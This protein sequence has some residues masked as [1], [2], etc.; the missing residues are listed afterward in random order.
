MALTDKQVKHR[1]LYAAGAAQCR[2]LEQDPKN[3]RKFNCLKL[4]SGRKSAMDKA[5]RR[6]LQECTQKKRDPH[7]GW[8]AIGDGGNCKGYPYLPRVKQGYDIK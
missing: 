1:C 5:V 4:L 7:Q 8:T 2:Y 6:Y 3:W